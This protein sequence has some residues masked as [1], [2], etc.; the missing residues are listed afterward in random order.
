ME[1][2]IKNRQ[3]AVMTDAGP[4]GSTRK[5]S[6]D[7]RYTADIEVE[8][9]YQDPKRQ[10]SEGAR[11]AT[12]VSRKKG[13]KLIEEAI[14]LPLFANNFY[15]K[16]LFPV[17][18]HKAQPGEEPYIIKSNDYND[19]RLGIDIQ[20]GLR[21][22]GEGFN[23][24]NSKQ[25]REVDLKTINSFG[26][27]GAYE[28][29]KIPFNLYK[30]DYNPKTKS[31][32][33]SNGAY[34]NK[35]HINDTYCFIVP[36]CAERRKDIVAKLQQDPNYNPVIDK[37]KYM[38]VSKS[39]LKEYTHNR[40]L[41]NENVQLLMDAFK[42]NEIQQVIKNPNRNPFFNDTR[43]EEDSPLSFHIQIPIPGEDFTAELQLQTSNDGTKQIRL[44][45]PSKMFNTSVKAICKIFKNDTIK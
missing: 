18:Q 13:E 42:N 5:K 6:K 37:A 19:I 39:K 31:L 23:V 30:Y 33:W 22:H 16:F 27:E 34:M 20:I 41:N 9:E 28:E 10:L 21:A 35:N 45:I 24:F 4:R 44:H 17:L 1:N 15:Q 38:W 14:T 25:I 29:P 7:G 40:I 12:E 32:E 2:E 26:D 8:E 36:H 3:P 43:A 11:K